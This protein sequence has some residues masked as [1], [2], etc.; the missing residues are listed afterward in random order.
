[1]TTVAAVVVTRDRPDPLARTVDSLLR[2][3]RPPEHVLV[4]DSGSSLARP[5]LDPSVEVL[6]LGDN[7]GFGAA[8]AAGMQH[9][10]AAGVGPDLLWLLDDDSP[11]TPG[12]LAAALEVLADHPEVGLLANRGCT[13]RLGVPQHLPPPA[14]P[15][16]EEVDS[17]LLDGALVRRAVVDRCGVPRTDLF[18]VHEDLDYTTRVAAGGFMVAVSSA[19][20]SSPEHLGSSV[21]G[22]NAWRLYY[23]SRN[24]VRL[25]LDRRSPVWLAGAV[26]REARIAV[27]AVAAGRWSSARA[28]GRGL[29]DGVRG[30]MGR[31]VEPG[32]I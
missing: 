7:V 23:Q 1:M 24:H 18:M 5:V 6:E 27:A 16:P 20:V 15:A 30:R 29:V 13:L 25:A 2:Q 19:V 32:S 9:L 12:S 26:G 3:S 28:V 22:E 17:A 10:R 31:T 8:L 21:P 4:V 11:V 14:R